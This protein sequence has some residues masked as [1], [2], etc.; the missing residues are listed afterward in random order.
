MRKD[1]Y[2]CSCYRPSEPNFP[3]VDVHRGLRSSVV[4]PL[5]IE[6]FFVDVRWNLDSG[7]VGLVSTALIVDVEWN[8][9]SSGMDC[10]GSMFSLTLGHI[11]LRLCWNSLG[12]GFH[13]HRSLSTFGCW[14][15]ARGPRF[16]SIITYTL[17]HGGATLEDHASDL[18]SRRRSKG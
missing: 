17:Q 16:G 3:V 6:R 14:T 8:L 12:V 15:Y 10:C 4:E 9:C 2:F 7:G 1:V 13:R 18:R 11:Y 5:P